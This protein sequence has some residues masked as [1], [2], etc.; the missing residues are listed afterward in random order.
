MD[1]VIFKAY[2]ICWYKDSGSWELEELLNQVVG[3]RR[4]L[5]IR[6]P[7]ILEYSPSSIGAVQ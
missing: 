6:L 2:P 3:A 1:L 7:L 5:P 4:F